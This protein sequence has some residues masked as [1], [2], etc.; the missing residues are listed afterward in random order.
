MEADWTFCLLTFGCKVNQ[1]ETQS[2]REA[3]IRQGGRETDNPVAADVALLNTCAVTANAVADARRAVRRL[4]R[5]APDL[6][7][8]VTGC[9]AA[10]AGQ[11]NSE[12][13]GLVRILPQ[14][15][16][17]ELLDAAAFFSRIGRFPGRRGLPPFVV[18]GDGIP[19]DM[20]AAHSR[21]AVSVFPPFS[22]C[23][24]RRA[25]PVL[26]VQ[27]G[28]SHHC[29]YCIVPLT[30]GPARS[31]PPEDCLA[32]ARRLL[33]AGYREIMLSGVNLRQYRMPETGCSDFWDLLRFLDTSLAPEWAGV[34]RLRISSVDP[35]QLDAHGLDCLAGTHMVCPHL[36]L[37]LQSGSPQILRSMRRVL[38]TP[39]EIIH[40]VTI[41][42]EQTSARPE[43]SRHGPSRRFGL[44]ADILVGFPGESE[45]HF[46]E[47]LEL[48]RALP[49]T[50]AH[51][52]PFSSRP[53]TAAATFPD[54]IPPALRH[55]RAARVRTVIDEKR[56]AFWEAS[57][58]V[59][60][61]HVAPEGDG[62]F[63]GVDECYVPCHFTTAVTDAGGM[64]GH[65]LVLAQPLRVTD[66]GLL[67]APLPR[68][69]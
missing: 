35:A 58:T 29:A 56:R 7:V 40:S 36:H 1:Y 24:F 18:S 53:G 49:L 65:S 44:G 64:A 15:R 62:G 8:V 5:L 9:A 31:R 16:K 59:P 3:W 66:D 68:T 2:V 22:I 26:K 45:A 33:E 46:N 52:F 51:V 34:A 69:G 27:D 61:L 23:G 13:P 28:C 17:S 47:T 12:L 19:H 38:H 42:A 41:L 57:L 10:V 67:V 43:I 50:Y 54:Q 21:D 20:G 37:S 32:E 4:H 25:R 39:E 6:H 11:E 60:V 55:E 30:R 48:V 14:A 63:K